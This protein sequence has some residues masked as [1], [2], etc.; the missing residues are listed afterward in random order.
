MKRLILMRH[1]KTEAWHE[2]I[3]DHGRALTP[4]GHEDAVR[5][6]HAL[7][8]TN[9]I[10]D[11]LLVSTARRAKETWRALEPLFGAA[12][13]VSL[14]RLYLT[15]I[16]GLEETIAEYEVHETLMVIGHNPGMHDLA[17]SI[18]RNAGSQNHHAALKL[19]E[20]MPTGATALFEADTDGAFNSIL[21]KLYDFLKPKTLR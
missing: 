5:I 19:S 11:M 14:E 9:W 15:G 1:A 20:K 6:G 13:H 10:P 17:R 7:K 12:G 16:R 8:D 18:T 4:R 3:D 21:L 2:G